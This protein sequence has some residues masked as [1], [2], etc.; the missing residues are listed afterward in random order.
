M[1][2]G[3]YS[4]LSGA[5]AKMQLMEVVT[6]NLT[7]AN[8]AGYKKD[9][10][11]FESLVSDA[12][13]RSVAKG[14]NFNRIGGSYTDHS[15]GTFEL[16]GKPFDLAIDGPGFFKVAGEGGEFF[17]RQGNFGLDAEGFLVNAAGQ[18][19]L[20]ENGPLQLPDADVVIDESGRIWDGEVELGQVTVYD[21]GDGQ[22]LEKLG[23]GLL[24]A[25]PELVAT[26]ME[27]PNLLQGQI[28]ASNVN[29][30]EEMALM[31]DAQRTF[32]A[33]SKVLK[34]YQNLRKS[35]ELGS[36]G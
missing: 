31:M 22:G 14:M 11:N 3:I 1:S 25:P 36:L 27:I 17:S 8:T 5:R 16:T 9:R 12:R 6:N 21:L 24:S 34:T 19:V 7:N 18:R 30:L 2:S 10:L 33:L 29:P 15:K 28:E 23:G 20:G 35:D 32:E 4:A 13:Q 26:P